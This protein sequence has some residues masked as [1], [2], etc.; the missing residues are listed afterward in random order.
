MHRL[1]A[2][3]RDVIHSILDEVE[4]E[5][6]GCHSPYESVQA[7][8]EHCAQLFPGWKKSINSAKP[9]ITTTDEICVKF[10]PCETPKE[11]R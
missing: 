9:P 4:N 7:L 8:D 11:E 2:S 3:E 1:C 10:Q 6:F 5:L